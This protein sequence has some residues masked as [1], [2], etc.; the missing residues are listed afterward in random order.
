[1]N[2]GTAALL[3]VLTGLILFLIVFYT[4]VYLYNRRNKSYDHK[5][6]P[7]SSCHA[8][9]TSK[10]AGC[11]YTWIYEACSICG[12]Q[13]GHAEKTSEYKHKEKELV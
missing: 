2:E 12:K 9:Q 10:L 4:C 7:I 11:D 5:W 8:E 6:F 3:G 1:M 13:S